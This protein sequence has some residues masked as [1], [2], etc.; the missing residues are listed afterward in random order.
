MTV[1]TISFESL[2]SAATT[3]AKIS[4]VKV[5]DYMDCHGYCFTPV[6]VSNL[7]GGDIIR[8]Y[9]GVGS[10]WY[11]VIGDYRRPVNEV[12]ALITNPTRCTNFSNLFLE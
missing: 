7:V 9:Y 1:L 6:I 4:G 12:L 5:K 11:S 2:P 10:N 3:G 8:E